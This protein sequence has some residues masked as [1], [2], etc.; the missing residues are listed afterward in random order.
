[1]GAIGCFFFFHSERAEP[2]EYIGCDLSCVT[3]IKIGLLDSETFDSGNVFH[4]GLLCGL[5]LINA[6]EVSLRGNSRGN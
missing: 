2:A 6:D 5:Q 4:F 1:M 3:K